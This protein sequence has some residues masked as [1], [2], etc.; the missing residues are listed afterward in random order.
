MQIR[1]KRIA[2]IFVETGS[3]KPVPRA[4]RFRLQKQQK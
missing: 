4:P 2:H 3:T 1:K